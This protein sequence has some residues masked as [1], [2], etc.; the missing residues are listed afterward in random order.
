M[1]IPWMRPEKLFPGD[2]QIR[3]LDWNTIL[4]RSLRLDT[5]NWVREW[6][7]GG[8]MSIGE[9][10]LVIPAFQ[11]NRPAVKN[12]S[13]S[14]PW[15]KQAL[16]GGIS[17]GNVSPGGTVNLPLYARLQ[18]GSS[19]AGLQFRALVTP[20]NN[21]PAITD[22]LRFTPAG[23]FANPYIQQSFKAGE[24]A[25]GWSL[26]SFNFPSASSN[27]LGWVSFQIPATAQSGEVYT[28]SFANADGAPDLNAQYD[29]ETRS[30][31]VTVNGAAIPASSAPTSGKFIS[32]AA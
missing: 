16:I 6:T 2:G 25:F 4:Q 1:F 18:Y 9:T 27:F 10:N 5:N 12:G 22:T 3:F 19:L 31:Y 11:P 21:A 23:G 26:P 20:Q 17:V 13:T 28:V 32:S 7:P 29:F 8:L 15:Y 24:T 30:A 14:W